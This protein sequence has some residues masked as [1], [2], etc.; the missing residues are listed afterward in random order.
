MYRDQR[1]REKTVPTFT[2]EGKSED[3]L[4]V[5]FA[6]VTRSGPLKVFCSRFF[7]IGVGRTDKGVDVTEE[8]LRPDR[9]FVPIS[10]SARLC[11]RVSYAPTRP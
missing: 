10:P 11:H 4:S 2:Q 7:L 6:L 5:L 8:D 9:I 3:L 1:S